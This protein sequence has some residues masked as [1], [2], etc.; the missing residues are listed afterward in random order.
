MQEQPPRVDA[1]VPGSCAYYPGDRGNGSCVVPGASVAMS[2]REQQTAVQCVGS[3]TKRSRMDP[4]TISRDPPCRP[5]GP[6]SSQM[7]LDLAT[8]HAQAGSHLQAALD[9]SASSTDP[10]VQAYHS[11]LLG[12]LPALQRA[13]EAL[14]HAIG[15]QQPAAQ[16]G[17]ACISL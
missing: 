14:Q 2:S 1:I 13:A 7:L 16:Y 10:G 3:C 5:S 4:S 15:S 11:A 12:T 9:C 8:L 6:A 17:R